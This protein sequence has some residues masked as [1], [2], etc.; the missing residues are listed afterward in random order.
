[1]YICCIKKSLV[2]IVSLLV[3]KFWDKFRE[4]IAKYKVPSLT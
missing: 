2:L 1:M 3:L 4:V